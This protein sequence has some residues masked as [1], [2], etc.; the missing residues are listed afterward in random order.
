MYL[1]QYVLVFSV[2]LGLAALLT[3]LVGRVGR[4]LGVVDYPGGRRRHDG[5]VPR[6]GGI[7]VL[8]AFAAAAGL[9][10]WR[11]SLT[12]GYG[13]DDL[14]RLKGLLIG[15]LL[16]TLFGLLDDWLEL[17]PGPQFAFQFCLSLIALA[18]LL[19]LERFT[20]PF[21]GIVRLNDYPWG[22][23]VYVPLTVLWVMGMLNTVNWLDGLDGLAAGVGVILCVVLAIH[24]RYLADRPQPSV[25][26]LPLAL[27]GALIGFLPYN[28]APARVFLG[29]AGA[30]FLGY[31]LA[32]LGLIAGGRTATVLMVM[33]LPIVDVA[34]QIF[35]RVRRNRSP[36]EADR[37]HLHYRLLDLGL[38]KRTIVLVYW[39]F[40]ALFGL[41]ALMAAP[42]QKL[43]ALL[44]IGTIVIVTLLFLSRET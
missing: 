18:T 32:A 10:A 42:W 29:S 6:L 2:S 35:D 13:P 44:S 17:P 43:M 23:F 12:A 1:Y 3:P 22:A 40:C 30:F 26:F 5:S 9:A 16:A 19:W 37:G 14:L 34:W 7:A 21:F 25:A 11:G 20:V 27:A 8:V 31:A 36:V 4:E 28:V 15:G 39:G 38:S 41:L 33:G 24:M